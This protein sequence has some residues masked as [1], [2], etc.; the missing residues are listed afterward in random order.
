VSTA[1]VYGELLDPAHRLQDQIG[2]LDADTRAF[3][4][5]CAEAAAARW[6]EPDS[7]DIG[8]PGRGV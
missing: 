6:G 8:E 3:L 5:A 1:D 4:V 2:E 7:E